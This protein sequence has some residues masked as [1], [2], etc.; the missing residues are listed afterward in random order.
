MKIIFVVGQEVRKNGEGIQ[1]AGAK[2]PTLTG[3]KKTAVQKS[4][5]SHEG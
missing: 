3:I 4:R 1:E 2:Y 5:I